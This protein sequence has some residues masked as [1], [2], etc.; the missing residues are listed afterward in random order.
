[1]RLTVHT[2][3]ALRLLMSLALK[4]DGLAII[5]EIAA[6]Y[7]ISK[8]HLMKV[9]CELGV[10]GY[11]VTVRGRGG[12]LR[13]AQPVEAI[14]LGEVVRRTEPDMPLVPCLKRE[15]GFCPLFPACVLRRVVGL[16]SAA[17][18]EALDGYTL[19][20]LIEPAAKLRALLRIS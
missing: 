3:Y 5:A 11:V 12:G 6:I 18:L 13:L 16:A 17:F 4:K 14:I 2:D 20:D 7:D 8:N 10:A 19:G 1:M 9:A 15:D